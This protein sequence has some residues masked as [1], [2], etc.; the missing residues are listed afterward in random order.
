MASPV[1]AD[2]ASACFPCIP[3]APSKSKYK[4]KLQCDLIVYLV[5]PGLDKRVLI[6]LIAVAIT[7]ISIL[8]IADLN[9]KRTRVRWYSRE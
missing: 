6:S 2:S 8:P 5:L 4:V 7:K 9:A 1:T 3:K